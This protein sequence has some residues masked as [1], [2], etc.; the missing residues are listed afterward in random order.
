[1]YIKQHTTMF[2]G[3]KHDFQGQPLTEYQGGPELRNSFYYIAP[4]AGVSDEEMPVKALITHFHWG[5]RSVSGAD[6][7]TLILTEKENGV[8]KE[9]YAYLSSSLIYYVDASNGGISTDYDIANGN[10]VNFNALVSGQST[11]IGRRFNIVY[12]NYQTN[13]KSHFKVIIDGKYTFTIYMQVQPYS[14]R[15]GRYAMHYISINVPSEL[16]CFTCGLCGDFTTLS[17]TIIKGSQGGDVCIYI[18]IYVYISEIKVSKNY[19]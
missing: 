9:Y 3:K 6:Y 11:P 18:Y 17:S 2:N 8:K 10:G 14:T 5:T 15:N 7:I 4:C 12:T 13:Y 1:M 16:K 19:K